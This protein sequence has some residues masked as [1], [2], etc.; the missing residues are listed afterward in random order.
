MNGWRAYDIA[1][2]RLAREV[3]L[4][5]DKELLEQ[6]WDAFVK[7]YI[8]VRELSAKDLKAVPLFVGVRQV[9]LMGL[10]FKDA[11]IHGSIDFGDDFIDDKLHFFMNIQKTLSSNK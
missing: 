1:E 9:W 6:L 8:S 4:G 2:F 11:H 7:G 3:R 10:C 5:H